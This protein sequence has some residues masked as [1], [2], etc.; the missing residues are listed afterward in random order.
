MIVSTGIIKQY[1]IQESN[2]SIIFNLPLKVEI[3]N[4]FPFDYGSL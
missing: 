3:M 2:L 1:N 4:I